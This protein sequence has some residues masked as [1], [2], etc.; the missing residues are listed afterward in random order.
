VADAQVCKPQR[1]KK[2]SHQRHAFAGAS[3]MGMVVTAEKRRGVDYFNE[4]AW[5]AVAGLSD[6]EYRIVRGGEHQKP[7]ELPRVFDGF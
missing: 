4:I 3:L 7:V 1:G 5:V 2:N 6:D